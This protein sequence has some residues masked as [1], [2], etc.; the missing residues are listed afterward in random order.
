VN[1]SQDDIEDEEEIVWLID[2]ATMPY[3][4]ECIAL[5]LHHGDFDRQA[6]LSFR[7]KSESLT[8]KISMAQY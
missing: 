2:P 6:I 7:P 8:V 3:V 4:R 5:V 1:G